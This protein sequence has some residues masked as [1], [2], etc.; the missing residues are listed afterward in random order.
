MNYRLSARRV[1]SPAAGDES[2]LGT[3][4]TLRGYMMR[5]FDDAIGSLTSAQVAQRTLDGFVVGLENFAFT[6]PTEDGTLADHNPNRLV[7]QLF[8]AGAA[9]FQAWFGKVT[10]PDQYDSFRAAIV[11]RTVFHVLE[12]FTRVPT[13]LGTAL[14]KMANEFASINYHTR[15]M[16][17]STF[18]NGL[19][20]SVFEAYVLD[21]FVA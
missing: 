13:D 1:L 18:F 21:R 4:T 17:L 20:T 3:Y 14:E 2:L 11:D 16:Y 15:T 12:K 9:S 6:M 19:Q 5:I 7:S 8:E 10:A